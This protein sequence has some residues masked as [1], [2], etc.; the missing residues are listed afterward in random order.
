M[1]TQ[2]TRQSL[3]LTANLRRSPQAMWTLLGVTSIAALL[4]PMFAANASFAAASSGRADARV[5]GRSGNGP[6]GDPKNGKLVFEK[7]ACNLCHG[8]QGEGVSGAGTKAGVPRIASTPLASAD[9]VQQVRKP[10]GQMPPFSSEKISDADLADVYAYLQTLKPPAEPPTNA[11][12]SSKGE[13]LFKSHGC[14]E[15][16]GYQG[17]GST[18]TGGSRLGPPRIPLSAFTSYLR[19]PTGQ[20]PPYTVKV[21]SDEEVAEIY[22]FLRSVPPPPPLK[23]IPLLSQ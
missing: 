15:C 14:Y 21:V 5:A 18:S 9:F 11:A 8:S 13:R 1:S 23:S 6:A 12:S 7:N 10:K 3:W 17:Q 20:M 19:Q 22:N 16:H 2:T 4:V